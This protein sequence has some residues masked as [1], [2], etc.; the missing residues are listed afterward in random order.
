MPTP[1][2]QTVLPYPRSGRVVTRSK[3]WMRLI[4][5]PIALA[6]WVGMLGSVRLAVVQHDWMAPVRSSH[7][8]PVMATIGWIIEGFFII[9]IPAA[10]WLLLT[11]R[12]VLDADGVS[13][14]VGR[15]TR[16][17]SAAEAQGI[18]Y[19]EGSVIN[20]RNRPNRVLVV[21]ATG[22]Q[23]ARFM[24]TERTWRPSLAILHE[25]L[26]QRPELA[27]DQRTRDF[28]AGFT[29]SR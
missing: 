6:L 27:L 3:P 15:R 12:E 1:V 4:G 24:S 11:F 26:Q 21:D 8:G 14:R 29:V 16:R 20:S 18:R 25:W 9:V 5:A 23:I 2:S 22:R 19:V 13:T 10:L 28:F 7:G 17:V